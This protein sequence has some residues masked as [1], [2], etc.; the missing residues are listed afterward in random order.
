MSERPN[1]LSGF[2]GRAVIDHDDLEFWPILNENTID[3]VGNKTR[4]IIV[5]YDN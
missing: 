4:V 2:I 5:C 1:D 3:R